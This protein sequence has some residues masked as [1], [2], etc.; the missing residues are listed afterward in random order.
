[1]LTVYTAAL[2]CIYPG[3][4]YA[5]MAENVG[6]SYDVFFICIICACK[7]VAQIVRKHLCFLYLCRFAKF[8]HL[9]PD[10]GAVERSAAACYENAAA[11]YSFFLHIT[12]QYSAQFVG[13]YYGS[14]FPFAHYGGTL[15]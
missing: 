13:K 5:R 15:L 1:M 4:V 3:C 11:F 12:C 10:V 6:K 8:V 9:S 7:K 14:A 2:H